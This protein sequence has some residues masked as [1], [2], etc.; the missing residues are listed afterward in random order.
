[1]THSGA[2]PFGQ[3]TRVLAVRHGETDWNLE[4]RIQGQLDVPLNAIGRWQ[5]G[6]LARALGGE[7]VDAIYASDLSRTLQTAEPAA[8]ER[9]L[10]VSADSGLRERA[11]GVFEGLTFAEI[12]LRWPAQA[13]RWRRRDPDFGAEGGER[14]ADFYARSVACAERI[15]AAHAGQTIVLFTHGGVLDCLYRAASRIALDAPRSWQIGN[16]SI[17]RLLYTPQGFVLIG[18]ADDQHLDGAALDEA[19]DGDIAPPT[20]ARA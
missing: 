14:L 7:A 15:A 6:R 3:A 12:E 8:R 9:G 4:S 13:A 2:E 17:N 18:W 19:G 20:R 1:M 16:A 5:A 11:F 10:G